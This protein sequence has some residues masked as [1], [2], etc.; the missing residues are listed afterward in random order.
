MRHESGS[1]IGPD[2][3]TTTSASTLW[4]VTGRRTRQLT[5]DPLDYGI[6]RSEPESL[7]GGDAQY[8]AQVVRDVLDGRPGPVRDA[9]I[10]NAAAA[11]ATQELTRGNLKD[12]LADCLERSRR[13]IDSGA[14]AATLLAWLERV[15]RARHD[16]A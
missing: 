6:T 11:I 3:L 4:A 2:G 5:I 12:V 9:V 14:A 10:L 15:G 16:S 1:G 8:N 7:R 13:A